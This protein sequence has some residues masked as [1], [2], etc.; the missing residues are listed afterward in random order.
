[1]A[2]SDARANQ[3]HVIFFT[4]PIEKSLHGRKISCRYQEENVAKH[5]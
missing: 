5:S 2:E 4:W 3:K 1:M